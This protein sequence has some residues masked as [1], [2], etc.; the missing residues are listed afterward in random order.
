MLR[1]AVDPVEQFARSR[2]GKDTIVSAVT[3]EAIDLAEL[4]TALGCWYMVNHAGLE[5]G[6]LK[7][8]FADCSRERLDGILRRKLS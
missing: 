8:V 2:A 5:A 4:A 7:T 1:P 6:K 3:T